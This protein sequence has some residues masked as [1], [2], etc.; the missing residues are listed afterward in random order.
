MGDRM[1]KQFFKRSVG[2][3]C[4]LSC[5]VA[6]ACPSKTE[7]NDLEMA[8]HGGDLSQIQ[9]FRDNA[10]CFPW[11]SFYMVTPQIFAKGDKQEAVRWFYVGQLRG[12]VYASFDDDASGSPALLGALNEDI[13]QPLNAFAGGDLAQWI[14]AIDWVLAWDKANPMPIE[15]IPSRPSEAA[16][17]A[18]YE[19]VRAGLARLRQ[20]LATTDPAAYKRQRQKNGLQ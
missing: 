13:G 14:A 16:Y 12:R 20:Q 3:V 9:V 19:E 8:I 1:I 6:Q 7:M 11:M 5:G 15:E 10:S 17:Q 18:K 2:I 4:A